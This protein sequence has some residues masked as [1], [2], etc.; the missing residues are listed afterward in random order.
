MLVG[1][2]D[3]IGKSLGNTEAET[4]GNRASL[5]GS[6]VLF[7]DREQPTALR[8]AFLLEVQLRFFRFIHICLCYHK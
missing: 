6:T 4:E 1:N 5:P 3:C 7:Q 2:R 8:L